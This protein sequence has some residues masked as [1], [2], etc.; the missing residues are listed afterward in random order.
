MKVVDLTWFMA[1]PS[2]TRML[3]D[4]GATVVRVEN[5]ARMDTVRV[6][7]PYWGGSA[8]RE[9]SLAYGSISAGKLSVSAAAP[10]ARSPRAALRLPW[11]NI[12]WAFSPLKPS[13]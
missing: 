2:T 3:A 1:G 11:A 8:G 9:R 12:V 13:W 6:L 4:W 5:A 7:P 10:P